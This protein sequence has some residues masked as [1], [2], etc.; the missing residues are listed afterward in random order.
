MQWVLTLRE[1][2]YVAPVLLD[3]SGRWTESYLSISGEV[4]F[5]SLNA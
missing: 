3:N 1:E 5:S 2:E 4:T